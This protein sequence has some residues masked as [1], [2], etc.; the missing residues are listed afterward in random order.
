M[1]DGKKMWTNNSDLYEL[2]QLLEKLGISRSNHN[3]E[4]RYWSTYWERVPNASNRLA[5]RSK[6]SPQ[7]NVGNAVD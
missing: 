2:L 5:E 6:N 1:R 3:Y 7:K 4:F